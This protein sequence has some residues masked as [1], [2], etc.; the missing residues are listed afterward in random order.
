MAG[1]MARAGISLRLGGWCY[2][3]E[4]GS[5]HE[6]LET[7]VASVQETAYLVHRAIATVF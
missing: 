2:E 1:D 3:T 4:G 7:S 6:S 5:F